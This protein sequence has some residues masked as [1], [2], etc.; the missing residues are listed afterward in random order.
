MEAAFAKPAYKTSSNIQIIH[1][2]SMLLTQL[3][4]L[5][6][7]DWNFMTKEGEELSEV[8]VSFHT[9][10]SLYTIIF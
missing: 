2:L 5:D 6:F 1:S 4:R 3:R 9:E 10:L 7:Q 8:S